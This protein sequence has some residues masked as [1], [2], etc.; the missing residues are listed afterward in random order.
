MPQD[1][2]PA[3]LAVVNKYLSVALTPADVAANPSPAALASLICQ[4]APNAAEGAQL[5]LKVLAPKT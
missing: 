4:R 3:L 5:L 2:L 1:G